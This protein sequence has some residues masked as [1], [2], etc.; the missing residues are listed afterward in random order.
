MHI[1][2]FDLHLNGRNTSAVRGAFN[3]E[4]IYS[5]ESNLGFFFESKVN[6]HQAGDSTFIATELF[7]SIPVER[8][9]QWAVN[10]NTA[11]GNLR[12][13]IQSGEDRPMV[14]QN[15]WKE[16]GV[17]GVT[18]AIVGAKNF[19]SYD[20]FRNAVERL[21]SY[22]KG[23]VKEVITYDQVGTNRLVQQ[24]AKEHGIKLTV[25]T[26][27]IYNLDAPGAVIRKDKFGR[28]INIGA[29]NDRDQLMAQSA[30]TI[31][32]LSVKKDSDD[33]MKNVN[34]TF[35]RFKKAGKNQVF[36]DIS[37]NKMI[38][39]GVAHRMQ[40]NNYKVQRGIAEAVVA[41]ADDIDT[42]ISKYE[43]GALDEIMIDLGVTVRKGSTEDVAFEE[44]LIRFIKR[45]KDGELSPNGWLTGQV[46]AGEIAAFVKVDTN[47]G[48]VFHPVRPFEHGNHAGAP[49]YIE[50]N[51]IAF[52]SETGNLVL[53]WQHIGTLKDRFFKIFE[54]GFAANKFMGLPTRIPNIALRDGGLLLGYVA[55]AATG[56]RR[57]LYR[58]QQKIMTLFYRSRMGLEDYNNGEQKWGY[59]VAEER[60]AMPAEIDSSVKEALL[61]GKTDLGV[62][63]ERLRNKEPITFYT[64]GDSY[65]EI[66][67]ML[68]TMVQR[69]V[70]Y[71][72]D[73]TYL[74]AS[75]HSGV[76]NNRWFNYMLLFDGSDYYMD[77][78]MKWMHRMNP[79]LVANGI[80]DKSANAL[81]DHNLQVLRPVLDKRGEHAGWE[82]V[83][84]YGGFHFFDEHFAG[85]SGAGTK[86]ATYS[87][88][89]LPAMMAGGMRLEGRMLEE[90]LRWSGVIRDNVA[91]L[92][93]T[94]R[95]SN[96]K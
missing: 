13:A 26:A 34:F 52:D 40:L 59:N 80:N 22:Q 76:P 46:R 58:R 75:H 50:V 15:A 4:T 91:G 35:E 47:R 85:F 57:L 25:M 86:V 43:S 62:W 37:N 89:A 88:S 53:D 20:M 70:D 42:I 63:V 1:P 28:P 60:G 16:D 90:V 51:K 95:I 32:A 84:M 49:T 24:W 96:T 31:I 18:L 19:T 65:Q 82:R 87:P 11:F 61:T 72:I 68:N 74:L 30:D 93:S 17:D 55:K 5:E 48:P 10:I 81:F 41:T 39:N 73:P 8:R 38:L 54:D 78:I 3:A 69:C 45:V 9:G 94:I 71:G 27:D 77:T 92:S 44:A 7:D 64:S 21:S 14:E 6:E 66:N 67:K 83:D 23:L 36:F 79:G 29:F 2:F 12:R 33:D 56:S